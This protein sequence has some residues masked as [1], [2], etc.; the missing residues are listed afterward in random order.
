MH[1]FSLCNRDRRGHA[2]YKTT[3]FDCIDVGMGEDA[4]FYERSEING[5][6]FSDIEIMC[7]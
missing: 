4:P 1:N 2:L 5:V 7:L 6:D 3:I